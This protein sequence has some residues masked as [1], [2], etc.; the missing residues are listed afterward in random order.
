MEKNDIFL[1]SPHYLQKFANLV[2]KALPSDKSEHF[3]N[4]LTIA[5]LKDIQTLLDTNATTNMIKEHIMKT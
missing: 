3:R 1:T 2:T 5:S 4:H